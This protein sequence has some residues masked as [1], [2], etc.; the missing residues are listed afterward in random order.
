MSDVKND[1]GTIG[2]LDLTVE[3]AVEIK[4]F[5]SAVTGWKYEQVSMGDYNDFSMVSPGSGTSVAGICH[6]RGGNAEIPSQW[7][8]YI[9]VEDLEKSIDSCNSLGGSVI[10]GPKTSGDYGKYC[11]IRDPAGAVAALF[12]K[13][14]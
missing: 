6:K 3:N 8:I 13:K 9:I 14:K 12:E 11:I 5:Y 10:L 2:W 7:L 4:N 1:T